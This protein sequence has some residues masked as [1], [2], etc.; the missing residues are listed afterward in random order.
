VSGRD[1]RSPYAGSTE[2]ARAAFTL[3]ELLVVIAII[4]IIAAILFPVFASARE[5][6]RQTSCLSNLKQIGLGALMYAQDYDERMIGTE[7][8][9]EPEYF[10]GDMIQPYAKNRQILTCPSESNKVQFSDPVAGFPDGISVEWSYHYAVNDVKDAQGN[11]IGAAFQPLA[12]FTLPAETL[13]IVDG[14]PAASEPDENDTPERH[15]IR[16]VLGSRDA[17]HNA[18]DDGNPR[19]QSGFNFV[20]CDG[21]AKWRRRE[22][23]AD[24]TFAGGTRDEE[25]LAARP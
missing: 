15:E 6:A 10:W 12:A 17:V 20:A 19:H 16:W 5:K 9:E 1:R 4:A 14:W 18:G 3:I 8:G 22:K 2:R 7:L 23:K 11:G 21:H 25:W 24:G 13:F